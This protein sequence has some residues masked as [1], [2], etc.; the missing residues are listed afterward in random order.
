MGD[1]DDRDGNDSVLSAANED[2]RVP[3][4]YCNGFVNALGSGDI[5]VLLQRNSQPVA[6]LNLSYTVAKSLATKLGDLVSTMENVTET[7]I[8]T[9][10]DVNSRISKS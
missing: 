5:T 4:L 8:L 6:M 3:K 7:R 9:T 10:D 1:H 2:D